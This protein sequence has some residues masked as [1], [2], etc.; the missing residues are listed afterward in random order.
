MK[1]GGID[2][3]G[4]Q[5]IDLPGVNI[6]GNQ[7]TSGNAQTATTAGIVSGFSQPNITSVGTLLNLSVDNLHF[8]GNE[9]SSTLDTDLNITPFTG[10]KVIVD[11]TIEIELG[12]I[13]GATS[14]TSTSFT[15]DLDGNAATSTKLANSRTISVSGDITGHAEF[16]GS[17]NISISSTLEETGVDNGIYGSATSIPIITIDMK[18]RVTSAT[19]IPSAGKALSITGSTDTVQASVTTTDIESPEWSV[20]LDNHLKNNE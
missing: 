10:K 4:S 17:S 1:I 14:I 2:F 12:S 9:I 3:N 16:D 7:D 5:E 11:N 18:G 20:K 13:T 8:D 15:G 6:A 19:T